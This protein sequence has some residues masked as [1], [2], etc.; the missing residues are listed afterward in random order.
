[1]AEKVVAAHSSCWAAAAPKRQSLTREQTTL[2]R[3]HAIHDLLDQGIG[4]LDCSRRLGISL[5]TVK[6]YARVPEPQRL[7]RPPQYRACLVDAYRD[8]LRARRAAEPG[9]PVLRLFAEIKEL[10]YTG[11]LNLL[12][13][14][15]NQGRLDG[16]RITPSPRRVTRWILTRPANLPEAR[17]AHL[18]ELLAACPEMTALAQAV[19]DYAQLM[20]K[21]RGAEID[22][23]MKQVREAGLVELEPFL[24]GLDQDHDAV[25]AG[26]TLPYSSG[27]T[28]GVN[29]KTKLI[30]RQMYG[31]AGFPLLRHR[32]LLG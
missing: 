10:G 24:A 21:R 11:G 28:E 25:V 8:H 2:E 7:R 18:D 14:Y 6:R 29:T 23:W 30:K 5:D 22:G 12:Y 26:L 19:R 9:V 15:V 32:I 17:R 3:W 4:L 27:P 1:V 13:K 20:T 16:D 31:R